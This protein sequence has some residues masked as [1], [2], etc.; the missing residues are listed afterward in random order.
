M[1]RSAA[2]APAGRLPLRVRAMHRLSGHGLPK[3]VCSVAVA[4]RIAVPAGDGV[5]L[6]TDHY[7]PL[8]RVP[9]SLSS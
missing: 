6:L 8:V 1:T 2:P 3:P 7:I 4:Q 5:P 9:R